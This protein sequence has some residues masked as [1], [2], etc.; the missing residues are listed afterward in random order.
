MAQLTIEVPDALLP[1]LEPLRSQLPRLLSQ[2]VTAAQTS[3]Q[4]PMQPTAYQEVLS[5]LMAQP[6][7][8]DIL[9]FKVSDSAQMRLRELLNR[10]REDGLSEDEAMELDGYEQLDHLMQMLKAEA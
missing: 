2:W 10:H 5:F 8:E 7:P 3:R 1:K 4:Q 9:N 6:T